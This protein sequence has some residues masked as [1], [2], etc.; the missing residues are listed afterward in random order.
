MQLSPSVLATH[1]A[2]AAH[3][4]A[5]LES[6]ADDPE[7]LDRA[8]YARLEALEEKIGY[9][10]QP[11]P[12]F[13]DRSKLEELARLNVA[14]ATLLKS[15]PIKVVGSNPDR[16]AEA[17]GIELDH[18]RLVLATLADPR[19]LERIIGRSD[20]FHTEEGFRCLEFNM[21]SNIGGWQSS[22]WSDEVLTAGPT[23][24]FLAERGLEPRAQPVIRNLLSYLLRG[25]L[26]R[27]KTTEVNMVFLLP[28]A[29]AADHAVHLR[30][31]TD[32]NYQ[33]ILDGLGGKIRGTF[34]WCK[35][36]D[37]ERVR[38]HLVYDGRRIHVVLDGYAG[39]AGVEATRCW[40][41]DTVELYNGPATPVLTDKRNLAFLWEHKETS[42]FDDD[43]RRVIAAT[44]PWTRRLSRRVYHPQAPPPLEESEVIARRHELVLKPGGEMGGTDVHLGPSTS[45]SIWREVV[46]R[47]FADGSWIAQRCQVSR[48]HAFQ[49]GAHG[50]AEHDVVWSFFVFG[51][52][53]G[54][55]DLRMA[56]RST[57]GVVN[58]SRGASVGAVF[59]VEG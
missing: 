8:T 25:A 16:L 58:A 14:L 31:A 34:S 2:L 54:G 19:R 17:Y 56:P 59:E 42:L 33:S 9:P 52:R 55:V 23:A 38:D 20:F 13:V 45:E 43:D 50:W 51:D 24:R 22:Y 15:V 10:F 35:V 12:I 21:A 6:I 4:L 41:M 40:L 18:A 11:W 27:F 49:S 47:A 3:N 57:E 39:F 37:L 48:P 32:R 28:E 29:A 36:D 44:V 46:E 30:E 53:F 5:Y 1:E 26:G 7:A